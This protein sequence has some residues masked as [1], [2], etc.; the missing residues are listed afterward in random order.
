MKPDHRL[1]YRLAGKVACRAPAP[2]L[3]TDDP[4]MITCAECWRRHYASGETARMKADL[5][6]L[7]KQSP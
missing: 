5:L 3:F 1:H 4:P 2:V 7:P 6:R